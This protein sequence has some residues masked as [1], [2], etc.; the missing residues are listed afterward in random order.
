MNTASNSTFR[1]DPYHSLLLPSNSGKRQCIAS[2]LLLKGISNS[3]MEPFMALN[4]L[5]FNIPLMSRTRSISTDLTIV[6]VIVHECHLHL[7]GF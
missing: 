6:E 7:D 2:A 3:R 1:F 4:R 5:W